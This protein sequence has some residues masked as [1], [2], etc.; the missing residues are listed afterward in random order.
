ML[1]PNVVLQVHQAFFVRFGIYLV[2]EKL[3]FIAYRN[4]FKKVH[5]IKL[6]MATADPAA[7]PTK[8]ER[9]TANRIKIA[10][11]QTALSLLKE[12][13]V[14]DDEIEC[15]VANLIH[16]KYIAGFISHE[17]RILVSPPP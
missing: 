10:Q 4:L 13:D 9:K 16:Q 15:I 6:A 5:G 3:R 17:H 2:L 7:G 8:A 14:D 1:C 11:L 12:T